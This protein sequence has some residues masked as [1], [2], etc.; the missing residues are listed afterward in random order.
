M[1]TNGRR[2]SRAEIIAAFPLIERKEVYP[3]YAWSSEM[4]TSRLRDALDNINADDRDLW[5]QCGMALRDEFGKP[6][7]HCG[8]SGRA[9]QSNTMSKSRTRLGGLFAAM[10]SVSA[11]SFTMPRGRGGETKEYITQWSRGGGGF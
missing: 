7:G 1:Q 9:N 3:L 11:Q 2:Y 10:G 6:G 8:T 5:L 4:M